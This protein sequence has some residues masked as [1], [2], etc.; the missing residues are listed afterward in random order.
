MSSRKDGKSLALR[1]A[2]WPLVAVL[3]I[4][5]FGLGFAGFQE[6][7]GADRSIA[8]LAY[9]TLQLF[10]VESGNAAGASP[11]I[12][13]EIGRFLAPA[14]TA[15][16]LGRALVQI[17]RTQIEQ[18]RLRRRSGHVVVIGLGWLGLELMARLTG[19][20]RKVVAVSIDL[21]DEAVA[22]ARRLRVPVVVGDASDPAVLREA[23]VHKASHVVVLAGDDEISAEVALAVGTAVEAGDGQQVVCLAHIRDPQLCRMLRTEALSRYRDNGL[24]LEFFNVAEEAAAI[25]L[26]DHAPFLTDDRPISIG[27]VGGND[28]AVAVISEA[29][30]TRRLHALSPVEIVLTGSGDLLPR[31]EARFPRLRLGATVAELPGRPESLDRA[32]VERLARCDAVFV[33]LDQDTTAIATALDMADRW[34]SAPLVVALGQWAGMAS[35]L[36]GDPG[37]GRRIHPFLIPNRLLDADLLLAGL[38]ERLARE[39]HAAYVVERK[40][41]EHDPADPA[42]VDW[43]DLQEVFRESSRAQ[44][45]HLGAKLNAIGCGLAP[46]T[47]WDE[48]PSTLTDDEVEQ[49]AILE[50][51]R[52][53]AERLAAG[54]RKGPERDPVKKTTP[55]LIPFEELSER[56]KDLDRSAVR[57]VPVL[58]ARA[59]YQLV[60]TRR[61]EGAILP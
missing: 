29:A 35:M 60:R 45:S 24:R 12:T 14:A 4:T 41:G 43:R 6:S 3:A 38:G 18:M 51:D 8:D 1:L 2:G 5:A 44:V 58:L 21:D 17:F 50:H 13:L 30:R 31:L 56:V 46:L 15:Y 49:L 16:A 10:T 54:W 52:W 32:A 7:F 34:G 33:C 9:L 25:M 27:V 61:E 59:G 47:D 55:Y 42:L 20:N 11:P 57:E 36:A 40:T 39:A 28:V 23:R 26:D 48:P 53:V 19:S 37:A 22:S